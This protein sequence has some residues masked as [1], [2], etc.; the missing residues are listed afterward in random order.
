MVPYSHQRC[1]DRE[2]CGPHGNRFPEDRVRPD[3][4]RQAD[5]LLASASPETD[6]QP[7]VHPSSAHVWAADVIERASQG[8]LSAQREI[9]DATRPLSRE[10][11]YKLCRKIRIPERRPRRLK[12]DAEV[13]ARTLRR[14][15]AATR[16]PLQEQRQAA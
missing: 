15:R 7:C 4:A 9:A 1:H 3:L 16:A 11:F 6:C 13:S 5:E 10:A 14:R 8:D 2:E 12:P